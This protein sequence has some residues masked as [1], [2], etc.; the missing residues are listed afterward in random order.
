MVAGA[1][2]SGFD[3]TAA[4]LGN[5]GI[6]EFLTVGFERYESAFLVDAHQPTVGGNI[7]REDGG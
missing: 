7:S 2:A 4:M 5:L 6:N 1:V 3:D